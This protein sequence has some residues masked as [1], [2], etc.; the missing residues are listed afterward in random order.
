MYFFRSRYDRVNTSQLSILLFN[1][2]VTRNKVYIINDMLQGRSVFGY[3]LREN[4]HI[5]LHEKYLSKIREIS[6]LKGNMYRD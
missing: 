4:K 3:I 1:Y 2:K 5:K 6:L